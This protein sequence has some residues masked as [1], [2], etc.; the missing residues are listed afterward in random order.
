MSVQIKE[1]GKEKLLFHSVFIK[2]LRLPANK[3]KDGAGKNFL[4]K[5]V[6]ESAKKKTINFHS[7]PKLEMTSLHSIPHFPKTST[8]KTSVLP[9]W[10]LSDLKFKYLALFGLN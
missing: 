5:K 10:I 9:E 1:T 3:K 8:F 2:L 7:I 4:I 6:F